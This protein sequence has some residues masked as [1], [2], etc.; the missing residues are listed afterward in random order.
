MLHNRRMTTA[1][2]TIEAI[3][4]TRAALGTRVVT[5]PTLDWQCDEIVD[6]LGP[7]ARVNLKLELF[8]RTGTFKARGALNVMLGLSPE[9]RARGVTAV[10]AGNHAIATAY[11]A[12]SLGL[13]AKVVML[14]S[15]NPAR[16]ERC[17]KLGAEVE[18][19][20]DG[21]SAFERARRIE[22]EEGRSFIHPFEGPLTA[23]GT[24]TIGLEWVKQ[25]GPLDAVIC[26]IGGGGLIAG[27]A[28]AIKLL[29]PDCKVYGVEPEGADNM[30][31]SFEQG[32]PVANAR[33]ATIADSLA[34]PYSLPYSFDLCRR[35]VDEIVLVSDDQLRAG[36]NLLFREAKLA[37]EPAAAAATAAMLG[38]LA[39]RL[40]G[41]RVGVIVCGANIDI[42]GF[43]AHIE[44]GRTFT[45]LQ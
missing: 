43:A 1:P 32:E 41:K 9:Q 8:Q 3:R 23:L 44:T 26:P 33:I 22:A 11:A 31:R 19:A 30:R 6:R 29:S 36:M 38:P 39:E 34:P 2:L 13:S 45:G 35:S 42:A 14:A 17:R 28:T 40:R 37:V 7:D 20:P 16:V 5:T 21:A 10:S 18:I 15:A 25:A 24:A 4:A 27:L 12:R